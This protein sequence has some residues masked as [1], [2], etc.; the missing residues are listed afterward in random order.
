M[1]T[2]AD[3]HVHSCSSDGTFTPEQ[4]VATAL[5][6][7]LSCIA[8]ADHDTCAAI[9]PALQAAV[10]CDLEIIP[11][12]ELT[13]EHEG[14]EIHILGYLLDHHQPYLAEVLQQIRAYRIERVHA[15]IKKLQAVGVSLSAQS[16]FALAGEGSVGRLHVA[17]AMVQ[18]GAVATTAEAFYK[19]IGDRSSAYV[20]GF[21][22]DVRKAAAL[23]RQA[24]G[25]PIL[26]HPHSLHD[27][28][29]VE[30]C[31]LQGIMGLEVFYPEHSQSIINFYLA[32]AERH[33]LLVTGGS[34][35][36]GDA[37]P[38][39]RLGLIKLEYEYVQALKDKQQALR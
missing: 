39:V 22:L 37:K 24:G 30:Y 28:E 38:E 34:D 4:L 29:L 21:Q 9:D 16:V 5:S 17:R 2:Y 13:A 33:G 25:I 1:D 32:M 3:L 12:I 19:Y 6:S 31:I 27:D 18:S 35:C 23:I 11:A 36:H 8:I 14:R 26:A 15:I 7:G 20:S 10:R